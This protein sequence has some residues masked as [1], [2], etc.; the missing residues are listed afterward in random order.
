MTSQKLFKQPST[1][2]DGV[3]NLIINGFTVTGS[4]VENSIPFE[5]NDGQDK[6]LPIYL[7]GLRKSN[8]F[9]RHSFRASAQIVLQR[10]EGKPDDILFLHKQKLL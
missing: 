2:M 3:Q 1:K 6:V 8:S 10:W 9:D 4:K 7:I 5:G